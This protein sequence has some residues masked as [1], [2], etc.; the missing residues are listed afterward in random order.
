MD[1]VGLKFSVF[2]IEI[3]RF[4]GGVG[5]LTRD[6]F[7]ELKGRFYWKLLSE[8]IYQVGMR[9]LPLIVITS[10]SIG[11]VM[12][13]Q[14]GLGLEK[15]GGKMYVPKL[16]A[17]TILREMGPVFTSLMLAAR[18]GAG[19]ASE[20]GSMVVTQQIDAIRALG[21]SPIKKIV[22]PRVLACLITLPI[23]VSIA[24]VVGNMGG[25]IIGATELN[26][27]PNF[28]LLKVL[29]TS[30]IGDYLSG[31][32]KTFFFAFFIAI[33]SCYFGLNVKNGTK[34]VGIATTK[35]VVVSSILIL[36]GD[37]FLTKLFWIVEKL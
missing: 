28:Y 9:S 1:H 34:E 13:L 6:F 12:S 10:I 18:V 20:I 15:F 21:T 7:K 11:M 37:F 5:L 32:G 26:L 19:I 2:M 27:D 8:Q 3:L 31:F 30:S 36:V 24:N 17:V 22:I 33:P 35:A 25:L 4:V 29:T 23:L 14:F 16:L